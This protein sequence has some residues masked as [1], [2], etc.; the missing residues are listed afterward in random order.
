MPAI[1]VTV[2]L[3]HGFCLGPNS[4]S[5]QTVAWSPHSLYDD[6]V[7]VGLA[8]GRTLLLRLNEVIPSK[9]SQWNNNVTTSFNAIS[10]NVRHARP[11]NV[12]CFSPSEPNIIASGL[13][14]ARDYA[15]QVYDIET[16]AKILD[17]RIEK[18]IYS[19]T[20]NQ[21][22]SSTN[23][24]LRPLL[25][26][27]SN[28]VTPQKP[29]PR[30]NSPAAEPKPFI[31]YGSSEAVSS[32]AFLLGGSNTS[33]QLV[34]GMT[35]KCIR[36]YDIRERPH[37]TMTAQNTPESSTPQT[38]TSTATSYSGGATLVFNTRAVL[39]IT[40]DSFDSKRLMS[41]GEDNVIKIWDLRKPLEAILTFS[42]SDGGSRYEDRERSGGGTKRAISGLMGVVF[43]PRQRGVIAS[44]EN[45]SASV[46]LWNVLDGSSAWSEDLSSTELKQPNYIPPILYSD[47]RSL[48]F[49]RPP[50]SFAFVGSAALKYG[51]A[52]V[53]STRE[54]HLEILKM[55]NPTTLG[56]SVDNE[57]VINSKKSLNIINSVIPSALPETAFAP[58]PPLNRGISQTST[59]VESKSP[60][61]TISPSHSKNVIMA[62]KFRQD[63]MQTSLDDF[64]LA[65]DISAIMRNRV[66]GGYGPDVSF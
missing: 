33:P 14:K 55:E 60:T 1:R 4:G 44:M 47:R 21:K 5:K 3:D 10:L 34:A 23:S 37:G 46:H 27:N 48:N 9:P 58:R 38:P 56:S 18:E 52:F 30:A 6:L 61:A 17:Q 25:Q 51:S 63:G 35:G 20:N 64:T 57:V 42:E 54:G 66:L 13:D 49:S 19:S 28:N 50:S 43:S 29:Q 24:P 15:L 45:N 40:S 2:L 53:S 39:G 11:C 36:L 7:A 8:T 65:S 26:P 59:E 22:Y 32:A 41:Y 62:R 16:A 12:V 31:Q